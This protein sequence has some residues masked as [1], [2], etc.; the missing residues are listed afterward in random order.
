M[1]R[2][3]VILLSSVLL[4]ISGCGKSEVGN[5]S[6]KT[7]TIG[8]GVGTYE[9]QFRKG[10]LPILQKEGYD[11]KIKTFSQNDQVDP[12][13]VDEEIDATVHQSRAYM[14]SMNKKI[15]WRNDC[16]Q[17]RTDC[18]TIDLVDETSFSR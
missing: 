6:D 16:E 2:F 15:K 8:F 4:V 3:L 1:K 9:E 7:F 13:L 10:I 14:K 12:A 17:S 5:R 18:A 11:V